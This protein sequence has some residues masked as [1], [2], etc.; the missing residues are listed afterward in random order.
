MSFKDSGLDVEEYFGC[1]DIYATLPKWVSKPSIHNAYPTEEELAKYQANLANFKQ[2][3][4]DYAAWLVENEEKI[5]QRNDEFFQYFCEYVGIT[6]D[7]PKST[8]L[9]SKSWEEGHSVGYSEVIEIGLDL[10]G[11]VL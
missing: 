8:A 10:V 5:A 11:L 4:E 1:S 6:F 9:F 3:K 7:H 2:Y